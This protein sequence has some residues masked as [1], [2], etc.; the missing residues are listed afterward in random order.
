[1]DFNFIQSNANC[2]ALNT[3]LR[4]PQSR[5]QNRVRCW[6]DLLY[7]MTPRTYQNPKESERLSHVKQNEYIFDTKSFL[8]FSFSSFSLAY[9]SEFSNMN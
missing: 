5:Q 7:S 8:L 4:F 9:N 1:M 6:E 3:G 2:N